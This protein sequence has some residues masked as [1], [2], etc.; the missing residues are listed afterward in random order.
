MAV[1]TTGYP[2]AGPGAVGDPSGPFL[3]SLRAVKPYLNATGPLSNFQ[4]R[5]PGQVLEYDCPLGPEVRP[6]IL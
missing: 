5:L 6:S 1:A 2:L 4:C 3:V